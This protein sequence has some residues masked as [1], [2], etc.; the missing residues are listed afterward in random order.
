[1]TTTLPWVQRRLGGRVPF[2]VKPILI[3][4]VII[5][6]ADFYIVGDSVIIIVAGVFGVD[7]IQCKVRGTGRVT[8]VRHFRRSV[9]YVL[10]TVTQNNKN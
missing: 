9:N 3:F 4:G 5:C 8:V 1:M 6:S 7:G 2:T 10:A